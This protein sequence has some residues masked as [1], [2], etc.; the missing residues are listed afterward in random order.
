MP[1][2]FLGKSLQLS[3][4]DKCNKPF[5]LVEFTFDGELLGGLLIG[6]A[7][8]LVQPFARSNVPKVS[9][10]NITSPI[11]GSLPGEQANQVHTQKRV[12]IFVFDL[13]REHIR[14]KHT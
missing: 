10:M 7:R 6:V 2:S 8:T 1:C 12:H 11:R 14:R 13:T 3:R 5:V 9:L 4:G